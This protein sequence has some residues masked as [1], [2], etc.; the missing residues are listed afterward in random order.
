MS[1][2]CT[3]FF[4]CLVAKYST[5][6]YNIIRCSNN[7]KIMNINSD[8]NRFS[9]VIFWSTN[10]FFLVAMP[11]RRFNDLT[12]PWVV[13][14]WLD[15]CSTSLQAL[16]S[17]FGFAPNFV[18]SKSFSFI[19]IRIFSRSFFAPVRTTTSYWSPRRVVYCEIFLS[20]FYV[21]S[22]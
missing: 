6:I 16:H 11:T 13:V 20:S 9:K 14:S 21:K 2:Q 1:F 19:T 18:S 3:N 17:A 8:D 7:I 10:F 22:Q 4:F 12:F 5:N 15:S